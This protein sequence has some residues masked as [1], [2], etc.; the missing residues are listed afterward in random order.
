M[1][2]ATHVFYV[3][4]VNTKL[5]LTRATEENVYIF[6]GGEAYITTMACI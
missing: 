4:I 5:R 2:V 1:L 3:C 6:K